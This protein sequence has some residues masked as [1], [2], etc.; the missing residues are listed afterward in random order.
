VRRLAKGTLV[1][2]ALAI[3]ALVA[4]GLNG[5]AWACLIGLAWALWVA[6]AMNADLARSRTHEI[7]LTRRIDAQQVPE[8]AS[9]FLRQLDEAL[10]LPP[11]DRIEIRAELAD[12]LTDSIA[13]MQAEGL[14]EEAAAREAL[15]RLGS[16][17]ELAR[18]LTHAHQT[19]RRLLAGAA[20]GIFQAG[21]GV[22]WGGL[23]GSAAMVGILL[24]GAFLA[25]TLLWRPIESLLS[26]LPHLGTEPIDLSGGTAI[27][28]LILCAPAF[29][30]ARNGIRAYARLSGRP[31]RLA[32]RVWALA[33]LSVIGGSLMFVIDST[34]SW[35]A[36]IAETL[37]PLSFVAGALIR[38]D[39]DLLPPIA[40]GVALAGMVATLLVPV[41][42]GFLL[43]AAGDRGGTAAPVALSIDIHRWDRV[44]PAEND[45]VAS[46]LRP[47]EGGSQPVSV[48]DQAYEVQDPAVLANY[49]DVRFELWKAVPAPGIPADYLEFDPDPTATAPFAVVPATPSGN[50]LH[51][52][53]DTSHLR[54]TRW[55]LFLTGIGPDGRR[56]RL[57]PIPETVVTSFSGTVWDWLTA[58][59]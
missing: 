22:V 11:S 58:S 50:E 44:A 25:T 29:M 46:P 23:L 3:A 18:Q 42:L 8:D 13:A 5:V 19:R 52:R 54:A 24:A 57:E 48:I 53:I 56:Y 41:G 40:R 33:G 38:T 10:D 1:A 37:V 45:G 28:A 34:Q 31:P 55:L 51:V 49:H 35:L 21:I 15:A 7:E 30:A 4:W 36:V 2:I 9:A 32:A 17:T 26:L 27:G 39:R 14:D 59:N 6:D 43:I 16:A 12:H 20:G 47:I